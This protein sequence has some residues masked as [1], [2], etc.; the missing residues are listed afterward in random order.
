MLDIP[1]SL[2]QIRL[3]HGGRPAAAEEAQRALHQ[4]YR[5]AAS[6]PRS[7][8]AFACRAYA[9]D[10]YTAVDNDRQAAAVLDSLQRDCRRLPDQM[11]RR[12]ELLLRLAAI[13]G[14]RLGDPGRAHAYLDEL[15]RDHPRSPLRGSMQ[16]M[17]SRL[18]VRQHRNEDAE[19][20][21]R[22][23][24]EDVSLNE[25]TRA[26]AWLER[27]RLA[28]LQ[29]NWEE[30]ERDYR[31]ASTNFPL[32][33]QGMQAPLAV[34]DHYR[35]A[36][37]RPGARQAM[38]EGRRFYQGVLARY[39]DSPV[40]QGARR[41]IVQCSLGLEDWKGAAAALSQMAEAAPGSPGS[42]QALAT[43]ARLD[44]EKLGDRR[45]AAAAYRR[46]LEARPDTGVF[47]TQVEAEI[48][49]LG[50]S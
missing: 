12:P 9:A 11:A 20:V 46:I 47:R 39:P 23:A 28:E 38:S 26:T 6:N 33:A 31:E 50:G 42:L 32:T 14:D 40:S 3:R 24:A 2:V 5:W 1:L 48:R 34:I 8:E 27:A 29:N 36:G 19:R 37:D 13:S 10:V 7:R 4:Y 18:F 43:L 22:V 25:E 16:L 21:L 35:A 45:A 44:E 17:R 49:R 30:A 15:G 41:L